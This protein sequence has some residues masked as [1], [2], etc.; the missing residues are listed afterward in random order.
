MGV[1]PVT[2]ALSPEDRPGTIEVVTRMLAR[3]QTP[4]QLMAV[5]A[6]G[7][8]YW[9]DELSGVERIMLIAAKRQIGSTIQR[10]SPEAVLEAAHLARPDLGAVIDQPQTGSWL[11][12]QLVELR[13]ALG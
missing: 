4:A 11:R 10:I 13:A 8:S 3:Y 2:S 5:V 7:R 12:A 6:A 9:R 1:V